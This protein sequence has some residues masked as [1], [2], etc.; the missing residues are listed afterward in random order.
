M[1]KILLVLFISLLTSC[2]KKLEVTS[3][4]EEAFKKIEVSE[5]AS[6]IQ[7]PKAVWNEIEL[8]GLEGENYVRVKKKQDVRSDDSDWSLDNTGSLVFTNLVVQIWEKTKNVLIEPYMEFHFPL[9]GGEIDLSQ[10]VTGKKGTFFVKIFFDETPEDIKT[11]T[12]HFIS[13]TKKRVVSGDSLSDGCQSVANITSFYKSDISNKG[14]ALNT[15]DDRF[16]GMIGGSLII[17][18]KK[19]KQIYISQIT[20][21]DKEKKKLFCDPKVLQNQKES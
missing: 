10:Y 13:N 12:A 14:I 20:F 18:H 2:S 15:T 1:N 4:N 7:V 5:R 17:S 19:N 8:Q 16:L 3:P 6:D 21:K 9:G 11:V